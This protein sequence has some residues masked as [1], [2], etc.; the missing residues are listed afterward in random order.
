MKKSN[1]IHLGLLGFGTVGQ[2]VHQI[3]KKNGEL[4]QSRVGSCIKIKKILVKSSK[5]RNIPAKFFTKSFKD[6]LN[7]PE[8]SIVVE[9]MGGIQ[10]A[11][12]YVQ[13]A[14]RAGKH[15]VTAN[16]ELIAKHG[17]ALLNLASKHRVNLFFEASVAGGIPVIRNMQKSLAGNQIESFYGIINGT[18]NYILSQMTS[19]HVS[20]E[21]AL[22]AATEKG[23]AEANPKDDVQGY[24][25][26]YKLTILSLVAFNAVTGIQEVPFEGITKISLSDIRYAKQFGFCIKLLAIGKRHANGLLELRVGPHLVPLKHPLASVS[27]ANNAIYVIGDAVGETMFYG[28]GAGS[29]PTG[30]SVVGDIAQLIPHIEEGKATAN[31]AASL[32]HCSFLPHSKVKVGYL[33][34][35][36]VNDQPGVLAA[37]TGIFGIHGVSID[38]TSQQPGHRKITEL[39]IATY[40]V[41][42]A[43]FERAITEIKKLAVVK[44]IISML[45]V[46]DF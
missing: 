37:I 30:S 11:Y 4:L 27:G 2:G 23:Y 38:N 32:K 14:I 42:K 29:L 28:P 21:E 1:T 33:V 26:A 46:V 8:I 9:L 15:V 13:Q 6:I 12:G 44:K 36:A 34:R 20:Y 3:L 39:R 40:P 31:F 35:L 22:K 10:P 5:K 7:D 43:R 16:K 24:D 25:A 18:T 19:Q 41:E 45:P 17:Q